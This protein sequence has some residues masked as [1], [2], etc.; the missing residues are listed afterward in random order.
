MILIIYNKQI[1]REV[2]LPNLFEADYTLPLS[3]SE[4]Q[5]RRDLDIHLENTQGKWYL[6][7]DKSYRVDIKGGEEKEEL[8]DG[9][10]FSVTTGAGEELYILCADV[11]VSF[12]VMEKYDLSSCTE[13]TIGSNPD[14]V[15]NY[16]FMGLVSS[17][18]GVIRKYT[19]GWHLIDTGKNGIFRFHSR[20]N[21]EIRL[22]SG[23]QID[24]FGLRII[25]LH[26]ALF[27]SAH[28][29]E[30]TVNERVLPQLHI[31][32]I[33]ETEPERH[34]HEDRAF[35]RSPRNLPQIYKD[36][37]TID[38]PPEPKAQ[39]QKPTYL[40][41]GPAFSMA[42]P[43]TLGC[44]L[45][46]IGSSMGGSRANVFMYTGLVTALG[47]ALIGGIWAVL[48]LKYSQKEATEDEEQRFNVYSNYLMSI[49]NKIRDQ[50]NSNAA[51][52]NMIYPP[53]MQCIGY[54]SHSDQLWNRNMTHEDFL[55]QR[56]GIGDM[57]FQ[58]EIKIPQEKFTLISD[59]LKDKPA[60]IKKEYETLHNVPVGIDL[61]KNNLIGIVGGPGKAGALNMMHVIS[62]GV[63]ASHS[64]T[65]V[66][67]VYIFDEEERN[68]LNDW[69]CM[70]WYPH[71][72]S[73]DKSVRYMAGNEVERR[74]IFF[75]LSNLMR[76][77]EENASSIGTRKVQPKPHYLL[78][79]SDPRILEGELLTKYIYEANP[80]YGITAFLLVESQ[81][82]LPNACEIIIRN[83]ASVCCLY[84][85]MESDNRSM[86]FFQADQI[87]AAQAEQF[88]RELADI[89]V[90][91]VEANSEIPNS[92][93]FMDMYNAH[94]LD[95]LHVLENWR[96]NRTY[97]SMKALVGRKAGN[98]DCY[99]DIH[100]KFHG[101]HGLVAGT[102]GSGKSETL[103]TYIL[104]LAVNFSPEDVSFFIIDFK[105]GGMANL[106][107]GLPH[108]AGQISNLS[109][110]QIQR[111]M[112]SI[113]SEN[114]RRQR[115]FAANGVNNINLYT[116][117]YKNHEA[118]VPIP[119]LFIIIDE[120]AE[121]KR[122][123][124]EFMQELIS[125]AQ[126][127]RSLGVHLILATQKPSG[128]VD[129]NIWSNSKFRLCL[130][131]Q[132]R[133][134]SMD[135]L[136]K[137]DAAFLTQAG[138]CYLQVGN[139]EIFDLFQSGYSG[140]IYSEDMMGSASAA[141][142][143]SRTGKSDYEGSRRKKPVSAKVKERTQ[144]E[145][146]IDYVALIAKQNNYENAPQLWLPVLKEE[147][148]LKDLG[149]EAYFDGKK[150]PEQGNTLQIQVGLY[151]DPRSQKQAPLVLDFKEDGHLAV[152]GAVVSGKSTFLQTMVCS[153]INK[154]SPADI[155]LYL[156][157]FSSNKLT[158][159]AKA[160]QV[161]GVITDGQEEKLDKF[162]H[163]LSTIM[164]ERKVVLQGGNFDQYIRA[165]GKVLPAVFVVLDNF[166]SF[167]EKTGDKYNDILMR[168]ARDGVSQG[169]YFV[170]ASMGVGLNDIPSRLKDSIRS[171]ITLEQTDK[172]KYMDAMHLTRLDIM[173]ETNVKGRGLALV[174]DRVLEFQ[175]ALSLQAQDDFTRS[176]MLEKL[177]AFMD[178]R[179]TGAKAMPIPEIPADPSLDI[180]MEDV[181]Y[182]HAAE[183]DSELPFGYIE[184][185]ASIASFNLLHQ[186]F[187]AVAGKK[188]S[189][190]TNVLKLLMHAAHMKNGEIVMIEKKTGEYGELEELTQS[191]GGKYVKDSRDV[192]DYFASLIPEFKRRN[193]LKQ[194][195][196]KQGYDDE[197]LAKEM[198]KERPLFIFAADMNDFMHMVYHHDA[199]VGNAAGFIEN[200]A[201]KGRLHNI[202]VIAAIQ[203]DD[204]SL[205]MAYKAYNSFVTGHKGMHLGGNLSGQKLFSFANVPYAVQSRADKK[206]YGWMTSDE[207][208]ETG[209]RIVLPKV[210]V[211]K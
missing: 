3:R 102:T 153:L 133:Q 17:F 94:S 93:S 137:P 80:D 22:V 211:K 88:G 126:V 129:D 16:R 170:L 99:L 62:A 38:A 32:R 176:Q 24:I 101:P 71:V 149:N 150:W 186:Y 51:A 70:R 127:G 184:Q 20:I 45:S 146:I 87:T 61:R 112:I 40:V 183:S 209:I 160:P 82:Q 142:M 148:Y 139:D 122:E 21:K 200:I 42:I 199:G 97:N 116:R 159:F 208:E 201:E 68:T 165:N 18:H 147:I 203:V 6:H 10:I 207:E 196:I 7:R 64:Y 163:L 123:E 86:Q 28:C 31:S 144:L 4:Y 145:A 43:M 130:R 174:D 36:E 41:I 72:W 34:E 105:G 73:E 57:P 109:G 190:K 14:C 164:D 198:A 13:I 84:N 56:L 193:Q 11:R 155:N 206:G 63:A 23:D 194:S 69:E 49:T 75:D 95:E 171:T 197:M 162:F 106:F 103:Q 79:V 141:A 92:L 26:G 77:R 90:R 128:T 100:E 33:D 125:V 120:F 151:D 5:L 37:I 205:L 25:Y 132:D 178:S 108:L 143:I 185:D 168:L 138:R 166:A 189:G 210:K 65:D 136:H 191:Y 35:N 52:M 118:Q 50:Y 131:V 55:Y 60:A 85:L 58:V 48:N 117:L 66:K 204:E 172:F 46:I 111:A 9:K 47:A 180:L 76:T 140:E 114:T 27:V 74:D 15:I 44:L 187:I 161:G 81:D 167:R 98:A 181:R 115:L 29:G 202:F 104:S 67:F 135:M 30:L 110:N 1:C 89:H 195:L 8:T 119:H 188:G 179:W 175:T 107:D 78:F 59:T 2:L 158:P 121:L 12:N 154:Y 192:F 53:V 157:D 177:C 83:D 152:L 169:I 96:K 19:D 182:V 54:N 91:E 124:P 134:D 113:K 173:P 156:I 39:K